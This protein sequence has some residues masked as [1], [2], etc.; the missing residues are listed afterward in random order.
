MVFYDIVLGGI[1][2]HYVAFWEFF[3]IF[4]VHFAVFVC[5]CSI[6]FD[7]NFRLSRNWNSSSGSMKFVFIHLEILGVKDFYGWRIIDRN[8]DISRMLLNLSR[9]SLVLVVF[10]RCIRGMIFSFD[11]CIKNILFGIITLSI[12]A[13]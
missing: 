2:V 9:L 8:V 1:F 7:F 6:F 4:P 5:I 12:P 3:D 13:V 10:F 11:R